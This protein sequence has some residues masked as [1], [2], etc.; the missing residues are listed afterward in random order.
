VGG[1]LCPILPWCFHL[2]EIRHFPVG[3]SAG[4]IRFWYE[5]WCFVQLFYVQMQRNHL[6]RNRARPFL[7]QCIYHAKGWTNRHTDC[8]P[9]LDKLNGSLGLLY[10]RCKHIANT[11]YCMI[12]NLRARQ[13]TKLLR[14]SKV[15]NR[16]AKY[17]FAADTT[18]PER[19]SRTW[20]LGKG[21]TYT[22]PTVFMYTTYAGAA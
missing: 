6:L 5:S 10:T 12:G 18:F 3:N 15:C 7:P 20:K 1:D 22:F 4:E 21:T 19:F 8:S 2:K 9:I 13:I 11:T 17:G 14:I 16:L